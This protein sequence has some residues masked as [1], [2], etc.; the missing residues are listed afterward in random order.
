[1]LIIGKTNL[2]DYFRVLEPFDL[3]GIRRKSEFCFG[4]FRALMEGLLDK[5]LESRRSSSISSPKKADLLET[6]LDLQQA[7]GDYDYFSMEDIKNLLMV[8]F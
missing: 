7:S 5:R 1:M 2:A 4:E 8:S 3:Q 6:L